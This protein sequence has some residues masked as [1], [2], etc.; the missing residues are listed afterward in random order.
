MTVGMLGLL[1]AVSALVSVCLTPLVRRAALKLGIM[2][3][4]GPRKIHRFP[5]PRAGG[6]A[7]YIA[8][9][10]AVMMG[11]EFLGLP[12]VFSHPGP[13]IGLGLLALLLGLWDDWKDLPGAVKLLGQIGVASAAFLAGIRIDR[14]THPLG[15]ELLFPGVLSYLVTVLWIVGMMNAVNLIDGLDGLAAGVVAIASLGLVAAGLH[16]QNAL[17]VIFFAA[18]AGA[19]GGFL[20]HNFFPAKIFLGDAGSQFLGLVLAAAPLVE[21]PYKSATAVAL[22]IPLTSLALPISDTWLALTRRFRGRRSIFLADRY[23]LH[24]RL[25]K[26]GLS[27][28]QVVLFLYLVSIYLGCV[29]FIFVLIP[30][31]YAVV[32]LVLLALGS[33]MGMRTLR[34]IEFRLRTRYRRR[35]ARSRVAG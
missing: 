22:L 15:G 24:H 29:A 10:V 7:V 20:V 6:V 27:H 9:L 16:A 26:M 4:P 5:I 1:V 11:M 32:L 28:R 12:A 35:F 13:L 14:L 19:C 21:F 3:Q 23:H 2:D 31:R 34:F 25:L 30:E 33:L 8:W 17:S 18:L